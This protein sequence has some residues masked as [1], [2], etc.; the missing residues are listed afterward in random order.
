MLEVSNTIILIFIEDTNYVTEKLYVDTL[1]NEGVN[2][3]SNIS[4][5]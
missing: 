5:K 3:I 2:I 1:M 4:N